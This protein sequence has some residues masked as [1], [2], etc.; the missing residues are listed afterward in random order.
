MDKGKKFTFKYLQRISSKRL[1][2]LCMRTDNQEWICVK[3]TQKYSQETHGHCASHGIAPQLY[4]VDLIPGGWFMIAMEFLPYDL[5]KLPERGDKSRIE[6][7]LRLAVD[8]L[9]RNGFVHG[10]IRVPNVLI[11]QEWDSANGAE[12][13]KLIDFDWA[14]PENATIYPPHVN[15]WNIVRPDDVE[16]GVVI[17]KEHDLFMLE[18]LIKSL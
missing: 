10:D 15:K 6:K 5:Y 11:R 4:A 14:G 12:N 13:V 18:E 17:K 7:G 9:H 2:F 8:T 3:F 1:L 16:D